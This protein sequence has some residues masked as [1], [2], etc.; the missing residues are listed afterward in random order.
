MIFIST[1]PIL[2]MVNCLC[3][4]G[5]MGGAVLGV[6]YY[7]KQFPG[8]MSFTVGDGVTIGALSGVF[9]GI[10]SP[11]FQVISSGMLSS[12]FSYKME[13]QITDALD[14]AELSGADPAA[15]QQAM[16]V[17]LQLLQ[18][19]AVLFVIILVVSILLYTGFGALGGV[20]GGN[21]FKTK[22]VIEDQL[23]QS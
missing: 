2:N 18:N 11:L 15:V 12:D 6:W 19:P 21:I 23:P 10:V 22:V 5:I 13:Q 3:C 14:N 9:A 7:R 20:I 1:V 4:A 17:I 8:D 16:D